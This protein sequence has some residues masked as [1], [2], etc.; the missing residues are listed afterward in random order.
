WAWE[1]TDQPMARITP[2][3]DWRRNS[4][5][6]ISPDGTRAA[7]MTFADSFVSWLQTVE[8]AGGF[9]PPRDVWLFDLPSRQTFLIA[10][11][12]A[13]AAYNG[14]KQPGTYAL[15]SALRWSPDGTQLAWMELRV[16]PSAFVADDVT[17]IVHLMVYDLV[18]RTMRELEP[19]AVTAVTA[20]SPSIG[21]EQFNIVWGEAGLALN[22]RSFGMTPTWNYR[23]YDPAN[24]IRLADFGPVDIGAWAWVTVDGQD[25]LFDSRNPD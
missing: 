13:D 8:G 17:N 5:L 15:R 1:G 11:Q 6:V 3:P 21:V 20:N 19:T 25:Y 14:P 9:L 12:P 23:I 22:E 2:T 10:D 7:Y 18:S 4:D 16:E 24:G